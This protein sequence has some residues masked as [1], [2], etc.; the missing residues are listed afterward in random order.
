ME[1]DHTVTRRDPPNE[2]GDKEGP[3]SLERIG[4]RVRPYRSDSVGIKDVTRYQ[5]NMDGVET[6]K[7]N[8][9]FGGTK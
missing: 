6:N 1:P 8:I 9:Y 5:R 2:V 4:S 3:K 7:R